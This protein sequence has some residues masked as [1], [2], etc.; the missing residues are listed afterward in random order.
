MTIPH[1]PR[2]ITRADVARYA[3]VSTAVVSY[4]VN[5]G[6]RPVAPE[7]A[8][9]VQ[10]AMRILQYRPNL[11]ARALKSGS[12]RT[13][14]LVMIDS[15]NPF[16]TELGLA[17][18]A[19]AA[20]RGQ[21]MLVADSHDDPHL[22]QQLV[23][24]LLGRRVDGLLLISSMRRNISSGSPWLDGTP[25][26]L[27]DCPGPV[28]G[29]HTIGPNS[30]G[31]AFSAVNHLV[32]HHSRRR[33]GLVVGPEDVAAPD[34]RARGWE[35]SLQEAGLPRGPVAVD[36]WNAA[37]GY[38]A[39][40]A[41]L[42][43]SPAPDSMFVSCDA[44]AV[45]VLHAL[46]EAGIDVTR[47]CPVVSFDG[48][49]SSGWTWPSLTSARQPVDAMAEKALQLVHAAATPPIHH[50]FDTELIIRTSCGCNPSTA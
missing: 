1:H 9:R 32:Q 42:A 36:D 30:Q 31:G 28:P 40:R 25:L 2:N 12:S 15:L 21:R 29:Y 35:R 46:H 16:F 39:A 50:T 27:L 5:G 13:L 18:E 19:A 14:G 33:V 38:R 24:E 10:D 37:G 47:D 4:V 41:L 8:L 7:T 11:N 23:A 26:V 48:T 49:K 17:I 3:G 20:S 45:G 22:E 6:P 34:P 43:N 44:Q